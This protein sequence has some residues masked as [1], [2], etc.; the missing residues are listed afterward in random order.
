MEL[1][2]KQESEIRSLD[3]FKLDN[4]PS[5]VDE[6]RENYIDTYINYLRSGIKEIPID[7]GGKNPNKELAE[8]IQSA[9]SKIDDVVTIIESI[10]ELPLIVKVRKQNLLDFRKHVNEFKMTLRKLG[11]KDYIIYKLITHCQLVFK[12]IPEFRDEFDKTHLKRVLAILDGVDD[13]AELPSQDPKIK[14][15]GTS[16]KRFRDKNKHILG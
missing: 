8:K 14:S 6:L 3:C 4:F 13:V 9:I 11:K 1:T 10:D 12:P 16:I 7:S 2:N 5:M 15:A